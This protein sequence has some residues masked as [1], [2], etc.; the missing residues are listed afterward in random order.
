MKRTLIAAVVAAT[1]FAGPALANDQ[2]ARSLGVAPGALS[3]N[4][5]VELRHAVEENDRITES[6][7]R[8]QANGASVSNVATFSSRDGGLSVND[9]IERAHAAEEDD[10]VT[11]RFIEARANGEITSGASNADQLALSLGV[12]PGALS[13]NELIELAHATQ[14]NDRVTERFIRAKAN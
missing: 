14:D 1:A 11:V 6:F 12:T 13:A 4:Q 3:V 9:V 8:A 10:T 2:L 5:L 7:I